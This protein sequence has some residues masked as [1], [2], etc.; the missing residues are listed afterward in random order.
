MN[1]F[2]AKSVL[3]CDRTVAVLRVP[4]QRGKGRCQPYRRGDRTVAV[5]RVPSQ[6]G[7]GLLAAVS[8]GRQDCGGAESPVA[9]V[10]K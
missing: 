3:L 4:S 10:P 2:Y 8:P 5:L 7:N 9:E 6:S 1:V